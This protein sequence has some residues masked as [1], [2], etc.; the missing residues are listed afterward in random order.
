LY[1][2]PLDLEHQLGA[3]PSGCLSEHT[4]KT[5]GKSRPAEVIPVVFPV[6]GHQQ[7]LAWSCGLKLYVSK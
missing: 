4:E 5:N 3:M 2:L 6:P 1:I 7:A